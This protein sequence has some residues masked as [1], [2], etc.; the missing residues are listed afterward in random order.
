M[1]IAYIIMN[2]PCTCSV[3][4]FEECTPMNYEPYTCT[5]TGCKIPSAKRNVQILE[6]CPLRN[7]PE[8]YENAKT[9]F[10]RG[11]NA[12]IDKILQGK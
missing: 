6:S 8:K 11:F 10:E 2:R 4:P 1:A 7:F 3:C 9:D 12:C 5:R